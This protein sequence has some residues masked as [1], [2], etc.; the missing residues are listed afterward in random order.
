LKEGFVQLVK[1]GDS[2]NYSN[3][4]K[5]EEDCTTD[6]KNVLAD[7][8]INYSKLA[9]KLIGKILKQIPNNVSIS[10]FKLLVDD[11]GMKSEF[12]HDQDGT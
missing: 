8:K 2:S 1:Y 3:F 11:D 6:N 4:F 10:N 12:K 5:A 9:Y 7:E